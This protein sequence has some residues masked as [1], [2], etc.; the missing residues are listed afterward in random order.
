MPWLSKQQGSFTVKVVS[1]FSENICL[2]SLLTS[3]CSYNEIINWQQSLIWCLPDLVLSLLTSFSFLLNLV[4]NTNLEI[5][6]FV[7]L[8]FFP[9]LNNHANHTCKFNCKFWIQHSY[10]NQI[11]ECWFKHRI[12]LSMLS[13]SYFI[14][15]TFSLTSFIIFVW[16]EIQN[17][18]ALNS[19]IMF[20]SKTREIEKI[21]SSTFCAWISIF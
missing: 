7:Y 9:T 5:K 6:I 15:N 14:L 4:L 8:K 3:Y 11:Y 20:F 2:L 16:L 12:K 18:N 10:C 17:L 1:L 13:S 21:L 19:E